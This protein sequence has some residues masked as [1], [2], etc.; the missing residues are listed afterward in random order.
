MEYMIKEIYEMFDSIPQKEVII[1]LPNGVLHINSQKLYI[2][3]SRQNFRT[4][5]ILKKI[6]NFFI[7]LKDSIEWECLDFSPAKTSELYLG[8]KTLFGPKVTFNNHHIEEYVT[9]IQNYQKVKDE[10]LKQSEHI[11]E[12]KKREMAAVEKWNDIF[13]GE[14]TIELDLPQTQNVQELKITEKGKKKI[15]TINFGKKTVKI[16][17]EGKIILVNEKEEFPKVKKR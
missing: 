5:N 15:G 16:V 7:D 1:R 3:S 14:T 6:G 9:F 13:T 4:K 10:L 11:T 12:Q 8:E 2:Y 17:T